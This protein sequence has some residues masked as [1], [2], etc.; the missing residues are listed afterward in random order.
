MKNDFENQIDEAIKT[1]LN[2]Y[3][4]YIYNLQDKYFEGPLIFKDMYDEQRSS[5]SKTLSVELLKMI[6]SINN[7]ASSEWKAIAPKT[8]SEWYK[9]IAEKVQILLLNGKTFDCILVTIYLFQSGK[10]VVFD[11]I[12][13]FIL[14]LFAAGLWYEAFEFAQSINGFSEGNR[15]VIKFNNN[16]LS[17]ISFCVKSIIYNNSSS[18]VESTIKKATKSNN[19]TI[20]HVNISQLSSYFENDSV[21]KNIVKTSNAEYL[22]AI[23]KE[24]GLLL[25]FFEEIVKYTSLIF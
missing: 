6:N 3:K 23:F 19:Y 21:F 24:D 2:E 18:I 25:E 13:S 4:R 14:A 22:S 11:C 1:I 8:D 9:I 10:T 7:D 16:L 15:N 5:S 20:T 12:P 17:F